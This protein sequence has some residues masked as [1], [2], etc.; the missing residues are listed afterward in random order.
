M[1][2]P[3]PT[4][5]TA[6]TQV[7]GVPA[8][9]PLFPGGLG[10][11]H[12]CTASVIDSPGHDLVLAAA[13]CLAGTGAGVLFAPGY[14]SGQ[15]PFGTFAVERVWADPAWINGYD[16]RHDYAILQVIDNRSEGRKVQD[17]TGGYRLG[18]TPAAGTAIQVTGYLTGLDDAPLGC[19]TVVAITAG[20]P[21]FTCDRFAGGTSGSPLITA[22]ATGPAVLGTVVGL[23]GGLH[24]GGCS[25]DVSYSPPLGPDVA[26]LLARAIAGG[27]GDALPGS[28]PN[29]C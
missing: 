23:I 14:D 15:A 7:G 28:G 25:T 18:S 20:F 3:S 29:E 11:D 4:V 2:T 21:G 8:V 13:H 5:Q 22:T 9:G 16:Q 19:R 1:T 10:E 27:T 12:N 17:L 6:A 24:E 26:A